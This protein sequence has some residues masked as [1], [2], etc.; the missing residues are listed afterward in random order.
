MIKTVD[1]YKAMYRPTTIYESKTNP[2]CGDGCED[3]CG[4][5]CG[6]GCGT[7]VGKLYYVMMEYSAV[8]FTC[9][10]RNGWFLLH[11]SLDYFSRT[12]P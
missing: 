4:D 2:G 11:V 10:P 1:V 12:S 7:G 5:G 6:D 8:F 3:V 9:F